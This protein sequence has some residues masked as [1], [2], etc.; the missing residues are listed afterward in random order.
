M[1]HRISIAITCILLLL[2]SLVCY[3][4]RWF[5]AT[6]PDYRLVAASEEAERHEESQEGV[7]PSTPLLGE[8]ERPPAASP[9]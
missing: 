9:L 3:I 8:R 4:G 2:G 5:T 6:Q 7:Q 1:M